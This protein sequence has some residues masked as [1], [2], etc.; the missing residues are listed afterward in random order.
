MANLYLVYK[1]AQHFDGDED[2]NI[3]RDLNVYILQDNVTGPRDR[4]EYFEDQWIRRLDTRALH[5]INS[6]LTETFCK[7]RYLYFIFNSVFCT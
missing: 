3:N 7:D 1:L 5:G 4:T 2:C 6:N